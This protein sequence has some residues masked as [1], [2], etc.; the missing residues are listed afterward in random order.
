MPLP[1]LPHP[2]LPAPL[3]AFLATILRAALAGCGACRRPGAPAT[4][5]AAPATAPIEHGAGR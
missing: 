5:A 2:V 4:T 1:R 3:L